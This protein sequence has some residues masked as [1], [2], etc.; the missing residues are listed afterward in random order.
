MSIGRLI[1]TPRDPWLFLDQ[2]PLL[3]GLRALRLAG[4]PLPDYPGGFEA[5]DAFM[6]WI[7]FA[8]CSPYLRFEPESAADQAFCHLRLTLVEEAQPRF[9]AGGNSKPPACPHCRQAINPWRPLMARWQQEPGGLPCPR[10]GQTIDPLCLNWR[11]QAGVG[12]TLI[13]LYNVFPGEA[14]PVAALFEH[15]QRISGGPWHHFYVQ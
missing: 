2:A 10:C 3:D 5:G 14:V 8:G 9:L 4:A 11:R 15:L 13:E 12:R 1:L 7:S 6:Q